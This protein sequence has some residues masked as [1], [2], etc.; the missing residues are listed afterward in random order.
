MAEIDK[1]IPHL[2]LWEGT[3]FYNIPG[4]KG[5][6]TKMGVTL[7]TFRQ[8]YGKDKTPED[9]KNMSYKQF[10]Y[11]LYYEFW[12]PVKADQIENQSLATLIMDI[13]YMSGRRTAIKKIQRCLGGLDV[14]GLVGPKTLRVLNQFPEDSF[15]KIWNMRYKWFN[16][17]VEKDPSQN[18]FLRGWLR[19][20]NSVTYQSTS[21]DN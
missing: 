20:L 7:N 8:Y 3:G 18:K 13:C 15:N 4:D 14:D 1:Y 5:G 19:R 21:T 6:Y 17:I 16:A 10:K 12:N 11:I 2:L 9:L